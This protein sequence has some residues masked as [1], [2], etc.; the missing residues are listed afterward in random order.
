MKKIISLIIEMEKQGISADILRMERLVDT[1]QRL[2]LAR[3]IEGVM[4]IV[5]TV[6]R[7]LTGA[8]GAT[9]VLRDNG[10]C[11]YAE[12]DAISPLWK[13]SRF[14]MDVCISGWVMLNKTPAVI[15]DIYVDERIPIDAYRPTFVKSLSMVPI[16]TMDPLGAIGNY[17]ADIH[18]P[19]D[20]EVA[21]LQALADITAVSIENIYVR[22]ELNEKLAERT[23]MLK[24]LKKQ[25]RQLEEF[26]HI[27]SHNLRAPLSNLLL[28]SDMVEKSE[29]VDEKLL[30]LEQQKHVIDQFHNTFEELVEASQV[31]MDFSIKKYY[32]ELEKCV[33]KARNL[34]LGEI[35]E[36]GANITCD[37]STAKSVYYPEKY[38]DSIVLNLLSNAI[39]YRSPERTPEIRIRSYKNRNWTFLEVEDNGVGIDLEK[40]GKD[41]FKLHKTFHKHPDARGFGLFIIKT[42]VE[43]M[44]G[45]ISAE[46]TLGRGT[47]FTVRLHKNK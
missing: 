25:N 15:R 20:E 44:G 8:D 26:A 42:Q 14:P 18:E 13:G 21:A 46:S 23:R 39:K 37:F 5:R 1:V 2:S 9:F 40:H 33:E 30:Y 35:Q 32:I 31:K 34:L 41:L 43:A 16:R 47:T 45:E 11:Y 4:A 12:E 22:D 17:W 3:D 38:L 7:E 27:V 24:Q 29:Q 19:S 36:T 6:A 28:L 10:M